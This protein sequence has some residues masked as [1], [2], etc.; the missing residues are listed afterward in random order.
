MTTIDHAAET[1]V[2]A[3]FPL[4]MPARFAVLRTGGD[5]ETIWYNGTDTAVRTYGYD[6]A[7]RTANEAQQTYRERGFHYVV[8]SLNEAVQ[9]YLDQANATD[10]Q[11][12][13][14]LFGPG[15]T[16]PRVTT[17]MI[18]R[19]HAHEAAFWCTNDNGTTFVGD[20]IAARERATRLQDNHGYQGYTYEPVNLNVLLQAWQGQVRMSTDQTVA[21]EALQAQIETLRGE[22]DEA[23]RRHS[24]DIHLIDERL[25]YIASE[26]G[27]SYDSDRHNALCNEINGDLLYELTPYEQDYTVMSTVTISVSMTVQVRSTVTASDEEA[28]TQMVRD[29]PGS[30]IDTSD[31]ECE[32]S[33]DVRDQ[34]DG[35]W[36]FD[37]VDDVEAQG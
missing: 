25:R 29:D 2:E 4:P 5:Q 30:Y 19:T 27:E 9:A 31:I 24:Q 21:I 33:R 16:M 10:E 8:V 18:L 11:V 3:A 35:D 28:A 26:G 36:E 12:E 6:A 34:W 14:A 20:E 1:P 23:R 7:H 37:H 32:L 13:T 15:F 22:R 17:W